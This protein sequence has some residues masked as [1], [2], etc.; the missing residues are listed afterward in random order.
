MTGYFK[1]IIFYLFLILV[2][3]CFDLVLCAN[4]LCTCICMKT[5]YDIIMITL[6]RNCAFC[7]INVVNGF[8][9][10]VLVDASKEWPSTATGEIKQ[11]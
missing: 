5:S 4:E 2:L 10:I 3:T 11:Q 8:R 1:L 6:F 7:K 9:E